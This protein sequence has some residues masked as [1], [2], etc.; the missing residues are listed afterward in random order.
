MGVVPPGRHADEEELWYVAVDGAVVCPEITRYPEKP[1]D[2]LDALHA[3]V[4]LG[5]VDETVDA[6]EE[7]TD[8]DVGAYLEGS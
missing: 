1:P 5:V 7:A 3:E 8:R 6:V 2:V 4:I